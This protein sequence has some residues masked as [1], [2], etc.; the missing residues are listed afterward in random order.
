MKAFRGFMVLAVLVLLPVASWAQDLSTEQVRAFVS[1]MQEFKPYFD[2]YA[3]EVGDDGDA[4]STSQLVTDW[5]REFKWSPEMLSVLRKYGFDEKTWP[6]VAQQTTQAYMAVKL[7]EDG[8]D[9]LG[10]MRQSV[11]EIE[12]SRDI[13][14]EYA[15]YRAH[16]I[17]Q[18]QANIAEMEKTLNAPVQDQEAVRPF[19]PQLDAVFDWNN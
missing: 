2:Q 10:Q 6:V 16:L 17:T 4:A 7:G 8:Q 1:V 3:E 11:K 18:M 9:V 15:E 13:P 5:A 12:T 14:A 19:I